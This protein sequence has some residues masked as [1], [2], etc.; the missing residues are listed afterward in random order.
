MAMDVGAVTMLLWTFRER[1]KLYDIFEKIC[2]A[3]FTTSYTRVG[4][5]AN[6]FTPDVIP[7][8]KQFIDEF[9]ANLRDFEGLVNRNRIFVERAT[10]IG[11]ITAEEAISLGLTGAC[12]RGSGI[13]HDLRRDEPYLLYEDL[14]FDVITYS[15]GDCLSRYLTRGGE[16]KES[17]KIV[18]QLLAKI[19]EGPVM[20]DDAKHVLPGKGQIYTKMEELIHDFML[21]NFGVQPEPG[22]IYSAI[23]APKGELGFYIVSDGTGHPWRLKIRSPSFCNLQSLQPMCE[24]SMI[25]DVVAIIGSIDPVMGEADK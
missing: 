24:G 17:V 2:G 15:E 18:R 19:P 20:A 8:I 3:R 14:D 11:V 6:D 4:G 13:P 9:P 21:I 1:E 23:E 12:L 7:M 10:G 22:E 25:S 16:M 5:L